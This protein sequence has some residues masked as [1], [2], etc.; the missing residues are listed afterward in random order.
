MLRLADKIRHGQWE[1]H[2]HT[3][4]QRRNQ[5][6]GQHQLGEHGRAQQAIKHTIQQ[7]L[8]EFFHPLTGSPEKLG[9]EIGQDLY[10]P[11]VF[12][13]IQ[14]IPKISYI[15]ELAIGTVSNGPVSGVRL[16]IQEYELICASELNDDNYAIRIEEEGLGF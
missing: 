6:N 14:S 16:E 5:D 2:A 8:F 13:A 15:Q 12:A 10:I 1:R 7:A 11:D 3:H 9:W 4:G